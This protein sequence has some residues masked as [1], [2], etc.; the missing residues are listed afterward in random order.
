MG[1]N[2]KLSRVERLILIN[3]SRIL[4]HLEPGSKEDLQLH[5]E[6]L[7]K[8]Y[9]LEYFTYVDALIY[10]PLPE[11]ECELV[12]SILQMCWILQKRLAE[13][14]DLPESPNLYVV[15]NVGFDGNYETAHMQYA[16]FLVE[17]YGK[18][19]GITTASTFNSHAPR[20]SIYRKLLARYETEL[21]NSRLDD[22]F[23]TEALARILA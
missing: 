3:Q 16:R 22:P 11:S 10:D 4:E 17:K 18:F 1:E 8:G 13:L 21:R 15:E 20:L 9:E 12:S 6:A 5:R 23:T 14:D 19:E 7:E 2:E